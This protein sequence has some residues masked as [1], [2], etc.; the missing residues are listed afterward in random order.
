[1]SMQR[2]FQQS[3]ERHKERGDTSC[4]YKNESRDRSSL[5]YS[6]TERFQLCNKED[7]HS[8]SHK[9]QEEEEEEN[10]PGEREP[11]KKPHDA[12][13]CKRV[14][15]QDPSKKTKKRMTTFL[16]FLQYIIHR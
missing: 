6:F 3:Q 16:A 14:A 1:M 9:K 7:T 13:E 2:T 5:L 12:T 8:F 10:E 11:E 4:T 15:A